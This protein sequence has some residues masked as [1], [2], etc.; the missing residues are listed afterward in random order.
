MRSQGKSGRG[1]KRMSDE[2]REAEQA[3]EQ[4]GGGEQAGTS[5]FLNTKPVG[6]PGVALAFRMAGRGQSQCFLEIDRLLPALN[7]R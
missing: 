1:R 3:S 2:L 5:V 6:S 7:S 4:G